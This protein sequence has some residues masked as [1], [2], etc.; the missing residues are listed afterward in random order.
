VK[1]AEVAQTDLDGVIRIQTDGIVFD[2]KMK[3]KFPNLI[4]GP[5]TTGMINYEHVNKYKMIN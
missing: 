5:K 2:K 1:I 3:S 4:P